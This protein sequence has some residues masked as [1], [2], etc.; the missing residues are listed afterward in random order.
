MPTCARCGK[1][2]EDAAALDPR[3]G[4]PWPSYMHN[5]C[6]LLVAR[7]EAE[8]R[9][10]E[11]QR[12]RDAAPDLLAACQAV[13]DAAS[14]IILLADRTTYRTTNAGSATAG[15]AI[16]LKELVLPAI[17]KATGKQ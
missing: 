9:Y 8:K 14:K 16:T 6:A 15:A 2:L 17:A 3:G 12:L 1:P 5:E 7:E 13:A 11:R 10:L 4:Q